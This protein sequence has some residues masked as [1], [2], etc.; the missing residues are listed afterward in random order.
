VTAARPVCRV[1]LLGLLDYRQAWQMQSALA[2]ARADGSLPSDILLLL[3]H[4]PTYTIGRSGNSANVLVSPQE[5]DRL[6]ASLLQ[7]DRGGDVTF[8]GPG[9]LVGYP[10]LDLR[11]WRVDV[12]GYL[13]RLE[14]VIIRTLADLS[15]AADR[16]PGFTGVWVG[17]DKIA[18]IGVKV[19]RWVTSHGFAI[20]VNTDLR[21]FQHIVPCGLPGR[22][23]TS[24]ARVLAAPV[25]LGL[26]ADRVVEHFGACFGLS[27]VQGAALDRGGASWCSAVAVRSAVARRWQRE[28]D[29]EMAR[30]IPRHQRQQGQRHQC[31]NETGADAS[32]QS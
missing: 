14:E 15:I 18:A 13:R 9:Q 28:A 17:N 2:Q 6:G 24:V 29:P 32:S 3:E 20:N 10:I 30:E 26:V 8:H 7:V 4:P 11:R 25:D 19:S 1:V 23:V 16:M 31:H 27:M 21:Y 5:L 12:Q 22:G